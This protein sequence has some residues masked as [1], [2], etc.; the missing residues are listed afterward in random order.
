MVMFRREGIKAAQQMPIEVIFE[1]E[2]IGHYAADILVED[3][4]I[5]EIKCVEKIVPAHR[6][7]ALNYLK[8]TGLHLAMILNFGTDHFDHERIVL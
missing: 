6:A 1:G 4:V 2:K 3:A 7:Q 5:L 8:A